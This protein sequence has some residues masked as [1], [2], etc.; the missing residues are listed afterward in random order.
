[1]VVWF[2]L[3]LCR[4]LLDVSRPSKISLREVLFAE[5]YMFEEHQEP[6]KMARIFKSR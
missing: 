3:D 2:L 1:M 4:E 5:Q 6:P